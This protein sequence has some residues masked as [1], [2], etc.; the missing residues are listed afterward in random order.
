MTKKTAYSFSAE[1]EALVALDDDIVE[2]A[3]LWCLGRDAVGPV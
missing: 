3:M 2:V 1:G